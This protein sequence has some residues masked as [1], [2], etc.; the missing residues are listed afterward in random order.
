LID[1]NLK[2]RLYIKFKQENGA[3]GGGLRREFFELAGNT[4]KDSRM[5]LFESIL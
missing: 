3:D 1:L 4:L 5:H 2:N